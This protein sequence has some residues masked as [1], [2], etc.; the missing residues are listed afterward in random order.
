MNFLESNNHAYILVGTR[1]SVLAATL[2]LIEEECELAFGINPDL[3]V[4]QKN[5]IT[6]DDI[7]K[8][9]TWT[10]SK[11]EKH[12]RKFAIVSGYSFTREG[13]NALLKTLEE[14]AGNTIII[15]CVESESILL[16][17]IRSRAQTIVM[18]KEQQKIPEYVYEILSLPRGERLNH[19]AVTNLF[20]KKTAEDK[21]D[22]E[23]L[24]EFLYHLESA[25]SQ[26][27]QAATLKKIGSDFK[28]GLEAIFQAKKYARDTSASLK[29]LIEH[30]LLTLPKMSR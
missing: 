17:T 6:I 30:V 19:K 15:V 21:V 25:S 11:P 22:R 28:D 5:S 8:L 27:F 1:V 2:G 29:M 23:A 4:V 26:A 3:L 14:P 13:Q 7:H 9:R 16:P 18:H 20:A 24:T 10:Q 12:S